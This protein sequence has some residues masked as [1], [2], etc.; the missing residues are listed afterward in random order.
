MPLFGSSFGRGRGQGQSALDIARQLKARLAGGQVPPPQGEG[1]QPAGGEVPP[2]VPISATDVSPEY[3]RQ[4][5]ESAQRMMMDRSEAFRKGGM[6]GYLRHLFGRREDT[7][8]EFNLQQ[9]NAPFPMDL[10]SPIPP[11]T[12]ENQ[13]FPGFLQRTGLFSRFLPPGI[14]RIGGRDL[15]SRLGQFPPQISRFLPPIVGGGEG[16]I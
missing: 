1:A 14:G 15:R 13:G 2:G 7:A 12:P 6:G 8:P 11:R 9:R 4:S 10:S 16:S 3:A 5:A